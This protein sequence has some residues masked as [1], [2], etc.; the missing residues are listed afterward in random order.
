MAKLKIKRARLL[1]AAVLSVVAL[2]G[3]IWLFAAISDTFR[4]IM[5][6]GA[7]MA[8]TS[9]E[10][11]DLYFRTNY[12]NFQP[13]PESAKPMEWH[14]K[15]PRAFV[16]RQLGSNGAVDLL[17]HVRDNLFVDLDANLDSKGENLIP[18]TTLSSD[19]MRKNSFMF[20]L[21]NQGAPPALSH[22]SSCV[23]RHLEKEILGTRGLQGASDIQC[24]SRD[25]RCEILIHSD[26]WY[27]NLAVTHDLY[28]NPDKVCALAHKFLDKYTVARDD[29][30]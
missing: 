7:N 6:G 28:A 23:P 20:S 2:A 21:S 3:L 19:M 1:S 30:R 12:K 13:L 8:S 14:L 18:S 22:D 24:T 9:M 16:T 11:Y 26:G 29:I 10:P 15:I 17:G 4:H 5:P 25:F 27:V